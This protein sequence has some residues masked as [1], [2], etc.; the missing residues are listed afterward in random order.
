MGCIDDARAG[1]TRRYKFILFNFLFNPF[2][3]C[4]SARVDRRATPGLGS[5]FTGDSATCYH[6]CIQWR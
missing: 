1:A 6:E 4:C 2:Y 5:A 3:M